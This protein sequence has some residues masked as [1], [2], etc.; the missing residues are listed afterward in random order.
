MN[1]GID[2]NNLTEDIIIHKKWYCIV[3]LSLPEEHCPSKQIERTAKGHKVE[4]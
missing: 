1:N 2:Q 4:T 3:P